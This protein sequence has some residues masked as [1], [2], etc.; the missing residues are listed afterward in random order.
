MVKTVEINPKADIILIY[1]NILI[2]ISP[3]RIQNSVF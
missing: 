3:L 2:F 1:N